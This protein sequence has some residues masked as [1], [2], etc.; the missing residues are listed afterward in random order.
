MVNRIEIMR[1]KAE[2][3]GEIVLKLRYKPVS[4]D[5]PDLFPPCDEFLYP[6]YVF[7]L[8]AVDHKTHP[9]NSRF[10]GVLDGKFYHGSDLMYALARK[11]QKI[12]PDLFTAKKM[13][14][15]TEK[16]ISRIFS[17]HNLIIKN[18]AERAMLLRDCAKK[19]IEEY[20]GDFI[21]L[22][23]LSKNHLIRKDG[24]GILQQLRKFQAY[25]DPLM[26]KSYLLIKILRRQGYFNPVDIDNLSFPVDNVL[27]EVA[28]RSGLVRLSGMLKEKIVSGELLN[29]REVELIRSATEEAFEIVA[30]KS[31][32]SPDILDDLVWT[33]GRAVRK[34]KR[35]ENIKTP[36]DENIEN[37]EALKHFL[38]FIAGFEEIKLNLPETWYF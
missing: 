23:K 9:A 19:L 26:K 10:E 38:L 17:V 37:K 1:V 3:L 15:V 31:G 11:A 34:T 14:R 32:V 24:K 29:E 20:D 13:I 22:L 6:N 5:S 2:Q 8:V 12:E 36:L 21:N 7:F 30:R 35:C 18:P 4:F 27:M 33:Y 16:D 28:V 25:A